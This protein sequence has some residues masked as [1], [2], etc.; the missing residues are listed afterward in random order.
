MTRPIINLAEYPDSGKFLVTDD[1]ADE[2]D[3]TRGLRIVARKDCAVD[4][5]DGE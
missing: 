1:V 2:K 5:W 4:Y 3:E